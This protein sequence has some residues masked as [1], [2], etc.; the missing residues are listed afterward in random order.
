RLLVA[1][2]Y[3]DPLPG[4]HDGIPPDVHE[5]VAGRQIEVTVADCFFRAR[6]RRLLRW[7]LR[8]REDG[9]TAFADVD[10]E[11]GLVEVRLAVYSEAYVSGRELFRLLR[12]LDH[13]FS[14]RV[15]GVVR[16]ERGR[17]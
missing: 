17:G 5:V 1:V 6:Q 3:L 11:S 12:P 14:L 15:R 10:R 16:A 8:T 2:L 9:K 7:P 4:G 13:D